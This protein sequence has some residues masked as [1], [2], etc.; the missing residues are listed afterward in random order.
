MTTPGASGTVQYRCSK[1]S[2]TAEDV[3]RPIDGSWP[4]E[5]CAEDQVQVPHRTEDDT[6]VTVVVKL[7][8]NQQK[9]L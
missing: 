9:V 6:E 3:D 5:G 2:G 7:G 1:G 4:R 8:K